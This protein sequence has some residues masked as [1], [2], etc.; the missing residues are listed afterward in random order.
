MCGWRSWVDFKLIVLWQGS[1][2]LWNDNQIWFVGYFPWKWRIFWPHH[3]Y[4]CLKNS[5]ISNEEYNVV[6]K[7]HRTTGLKNLGELN[8]LDNFQDTIILCD[9]FESRSVYLQ[10]M[11]KFNPKKC[12]Y[13]SSFSGFVHRDKSNC[14]VALPT[15]TEQARTLISGFWN[16]PDKWF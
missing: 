7:L 6:K 8:K 12:N 9:I 2:S 16:S 3:F 13:A 10:K 1:Y 11:F 5:T 4:S 15:N 14:L